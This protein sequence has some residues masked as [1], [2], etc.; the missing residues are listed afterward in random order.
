[1]SIDRDLNESSFCGNKLQCTHQLQCCLSIYTCFKLMHKITLYLANNEA[2]SV[3][4][5]AGSVLVIPSF[6]SLFS[7][8]GANVLL[9]LLSAGV[10]LCVRLAI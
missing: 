2:S 9:P 1:V 4:N 3:V 7:I 10:N 5:S 8:L 6:F